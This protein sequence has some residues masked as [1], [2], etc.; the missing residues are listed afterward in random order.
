MK[1]LIPPKD[2][3]RP[4]IPR[5]AFLRLS[6][7]LAATGMLSCCHNYDFLDAWAMPATQDD[8]LIDW[9]DGRLINLSQGET[10]VCSTLKSGQLYCLFLYNSS[11]SDHNVDVTLVWSNSQPPVT[12][13]VPGTEG[14]QGPASLVLVSGRDTTTISAAI[15]QTSSGSIE[16]CIGS[17]D[18]PTNT[19]GLRNRR[20]PG[21]GK[22]SPLL[23][24]SRDYAVPEC[25]WYQLTLENKYNQSLVIQFQQHS[26]VIY[27]VNPAVDAQAFVTSLITALGSVKRDQD[28]RVE[29]PS[30]GEL[31]QYLSIQFQGDGAQRVWMSFSSEQDSRDTFITLQALNPQPDAKPAAVQALPGGQVYKQPLLHAAPQPVS[32]Q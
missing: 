6:L 17:V 25:S 14:N 1:N 32:K 26:A 30:Q 29:Q 7:G 15:T 27:I 19:E 5:R 21:N 4:D 10:A 20:L 24:H 16:C 31:P 9:D 23:K 18:M 12:V 13:T 2:D 22:P 8:N 3:L 11:A 28:Y